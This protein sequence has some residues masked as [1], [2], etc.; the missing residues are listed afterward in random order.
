MYDGS[1]LPMQVSSSKW[2]CK[3]QGDGK[4]TDFETLSYIS[5]DRDGFEKTS[6][7]FMPETSPPAHGEVDWGL[8]LFGNSFLASTS[9]CPGRDGMPWRDSAASYPFGTTSAGCCSETWGTAGPTVLWVGIGWHREG[10]LA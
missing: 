7:L 1:A 5:T 4:R 2:C 9:Q 6:G 3:C 8:Q 10:Q